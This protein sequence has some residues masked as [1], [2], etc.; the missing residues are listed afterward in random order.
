MNS[1]ELAN[2]IYHKKSFLCIGLDAEIDQ[3]PECIAPTPAGLIKFYKDIIDSTQDLAIAYK[4]NIA[5]LEVMGAKGWDLLGEILSLIPKNCLSIADAKRADIGNTSQRYART[6]FE[7]YQFD[8]ITVAPYMGQ[9]SLAPFLDYVNKWV[10]ILGLTSNP[11]A[12]D[13]QHL[14]I[15]GKPLYMHV[16]TTFSKLSTAANIG[17]V[18]GATEPQWFDAIRNLI[19]DKLLLVPGVGAQGGKVADLL[20]SANFALPA[21]PG[22]LINASRSILFASKGEDY[23]QAAQNAALSLKLEME[24]TF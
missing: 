16:L 5:F 2:Q 13:F 14:I 24:A 11:G 12:K 8:A 7:T 18:V 20:P 23:A 4:I 15:D 22:M 10:F 3:L 1:Y 21:Q 9:D 6:F 17:F 19:P